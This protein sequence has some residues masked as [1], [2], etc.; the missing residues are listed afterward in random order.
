MNPEELRHNAV[1]W[2]FGML[3]TPEHFLRQERYLESIML[4]MTR[5]THDSFGLI[6]GGARLPESEFGAVRHDPIVALSEDEHALRITVSQCRG[7]TASGTPVEIDSANPLHQQFSRADLEGLR[8]TRVYIVAPP[9]AFQLADGRPDEHNP[10]MQTERVRACRL[11]LQPHGDDIDHALVVGKIRRSESGLAFQKDPSFIPPCTTLTAFSELCAAWR[12][13]LDQLTALS[14]RFI[15]LHRAIQEYIELTRERGIDVG[16]DRDTL[17]FVRRIIPGSEACLYSCLNPLQTPAQFFSS[18][19]MFLHGAAVNLDLTPPVQQY[20]DA[21]RSAGETAF[22]PLIERQKQLL[23]T[24]HARRVEDDLGSEV[25]FAKSS[26]RSLQ[27][28][29]SAL[30]GK[31][32]DF[33]ASPTVD[34]MSFVFDRGGSAL[35]KLAARPAR[36]QGF[37]DEMTFHFANIR[38]EGREKYRL[39]LTSEQG[40]EYD[41]ET[42]VPVEVR[43]NESSGTRREPLHGVALVRFA[44]QRNVELDFDAPDIATV[45]D[46]RVSVPAQFHVRTALLFVR[47]RFYAQESARASESAPA[48]ESSRRMNALPAR[49]E[50]EPA[51]ASASFRPPL[52]SVQSVPRR[53]PWEAREEQEPAP[54]PPPRRRRLE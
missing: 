19:H 15:E 42:R 11:T 13:I 9:Q 35:Y 24:S 12:Q 20:F 50:L 44:G 26:L 22:A 32:I 18:L 33:R 14:A 25:R 30:E 28:L 54:A 10:Q 52:R 43:I 16:I 4:W 27:T 46:L 29:E 39:I 31:Y 48:P 38:L 41:A 45:T 36:L 34:S 37:T 51:A 21:L 49:E 8:E 2:E 53:S 5:Y 23:R 17:E 6:G 47:H 1:N 7:L 40:H 3:V